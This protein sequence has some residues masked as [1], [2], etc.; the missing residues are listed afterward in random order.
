MSMI[1]LRPLSPDEIPI[2]RRFLEAHPRQS[3]DYAIFNILTWGKVY[4]N[5]YTIWKEHLVIFNQMYSNVFY[6]VGAG[7]K[8]EVLHELINLF[9]EIDPNAKMVLVPEDWQSANPDLEE[10]FN[11]R[12]ERDWADYIYSAELMVT[13][14]GK[15]LAKK[16]NLI[17][18]FRR[19]Y[20]DYHVLP[21]TKD[22]HEVLLRFTEKWRR[23][24]GAEGSYLDTEMKAIRNSLEL[25]DKIP[26]EGIIICH[27][28]KI[29]A[30]SVFSPLN[31]E[32]ATVHF[33]KFDPSMKGSAQI[34]NWETAK[35]LQSRFKWI[36]REQDI[37]LKGLRQAKL[38]YQPEHLV[39]FIFAELKS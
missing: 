15:K 24:R 27:E 22:K 30:Y 25:W 21:L 20:P 39:P 18:Q 16:K 34:I 1:E 9:R 2:L 5:H 6:P 35:V 23:E 12:E 13:L 17:S 36:N 38:S 29:S 14:S 31:S 37:G 10:Y 33:E 7:L 3:C 19:A 28:N 8:S 11:L 4:N 26:A 32:T